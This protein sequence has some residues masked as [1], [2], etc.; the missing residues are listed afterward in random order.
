MG[1]QNAVVLTIDADLKRSLKVYL[2]GC[3]WEAT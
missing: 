2:E 3:F 1:G